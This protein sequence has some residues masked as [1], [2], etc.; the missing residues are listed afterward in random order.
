MYSRLTR[1]HVI[2]HIRSR[3]GRGAGGGDLTHIG[4]SSFINSLPN[5]AGFQAAHVPPFSALTLSLSLFHF[6]ARP[7]AR[8]PFLS[9]FPQLFSGTPFFTFRH[10]FS[11]HFPRFLSNS[12]VHHPRLSSSPRP[13]LFLRLATTALTNFIRGTAVPATAL[14][15]NEIIHR[16]TC[17]REIIPGVTRVI[18]TAVPFFLWKIF[19]SEKIRRTFYR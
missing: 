15:L 6:L 9:H 4:A 7:D 8:L 16:R 13:P 1:K 18:L 19:E 17:T 11:S 3:A 12:P 10:P 5:P 14:G 2:L